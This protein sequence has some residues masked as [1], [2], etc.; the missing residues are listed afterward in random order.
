M[1]KESTEKLYFEYYKLCELVEHYSLLQLRSL[2]ESFQKGSD[3]GITDYICSLKS[4]S[5]ETNFD[6]PEFE[7]LLK[8]EFEELKKQT[9]F[10]PFQV[11]IIFKASNEFLTDYIKGIEHSIEEI[12]NS[13]DK[14]KC[15]LKGRIKA[16]GPFDSDEI[17]EAI[18]LLKN[19]IARTTPVRIYTVWKE[20]YEK[21]KKRASAHGSIFWPSRN[22]EYYEDLISRYKIYELYEFNEFHKVFEEVNREIEQ[23]LLSKLEEQNA[24]VSDFILSISRSKNL[25]NKFKPLINVALCNI[26][27]KQHSEGFW[28]RFFDEETPDIDLSADSTLCFLKF[29][30]NKKYLDAGIKGA[31]WLLENQNADGSWTSTITQKP[32][33]FITLIA[34]ES[35]VRSKIKAQRAIDNGIDWLMSQQTAFG[36]WDDILLN[37]AIIDFLENIKSINTELTPYLKISKSYLSKSLELAQEEE[38]DYHRIAITTAFHGLEFF[39]YGLLNETSINVK[40]YDSKS[41]KTIGFRSAF[42]KLQEYLQ[43]AKILNPNERLHNAGDLD[44]LAY[45]RDEIVHKAAAVDMENTLHSINKAIDFMSKY[46]KEIL[47]YDIWY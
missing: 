40:V 10:D 31:K 34:L 11:P 47:G 45:I 25:L 44:S 22:P 6:F 15:L 37:V 5:E 30:Q 32:N 42:S 1:D 3:A 39:L 9:V 43:Q 28:I 20:S 24:E 16:N 26:Y 14:T 23:E 18:T 12:P 36:G 46:S 8:S 33:A 27:N 38:M 35:V 4:Y 19:E 29:T 21:H 13:I 2:T 7:K 41:N 17:Y